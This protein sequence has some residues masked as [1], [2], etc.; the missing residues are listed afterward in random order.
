LRDLPANWLLYRES[1]G[2]H[3]RIANG[4][5]VLDERNREVGEPGTHEFLG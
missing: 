3:R 1:P 2:G 5:E 4:H